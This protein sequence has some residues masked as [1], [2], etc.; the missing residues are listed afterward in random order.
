MRDVKLKW[1]NDVVIN[2]KKVA[3]ILIESVQ[4]EGEEIFA[5]VGVGLNVHHSESIDNAH[6]SS[7]YRFR[8]AWLQSYS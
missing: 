5:I 1:P 4:G 2:D 7:I 3:G 8:R 6:R